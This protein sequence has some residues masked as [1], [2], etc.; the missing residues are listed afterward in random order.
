MNTPNFISQI[1]LNWPDL[2]KSNYDGQEIVVFY[3]AEDY[4]GGYGHH[5]HTAFGINKDG[6]IVRCH[7][8]G[9]SCGCSVSVDKVSLLDAAQA[10]DEVGFQTFELDYNKIDTHNFS[11]Y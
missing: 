11:S 10:M 3:T 6:E 7:S 1:R 8:S 4:N 9:C 5:S 2:P